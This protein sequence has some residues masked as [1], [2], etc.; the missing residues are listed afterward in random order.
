VSRLVRIYLSA[1]SIRV[2]MNFKRFLA[3]G[4]LIFLLTTNA[5]HGGVSKLVD[6]VSVQLAPP[7]KQTTKAQVSIPISIEGGMPLGLVLFNVGIDSSRLA[8]LSQDILKIYRPEGSVLVEEFS[9]SKTEAE[10][11]G[12]LEVFPSPSPPPGVVLY[13]AED[14]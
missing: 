8:V 4:F 13:R 6:G 11:W 5:L 7:E 10:E 2:L 9:L 3:S 1:G 12:E 14:Y